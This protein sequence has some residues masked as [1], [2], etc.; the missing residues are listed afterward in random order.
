[1]FGLAADRHQHDVGLDRLGRAALGGLDGER[2]L[3]AVARHAG[4]LGASRNS[5][6]CFLKILLAS[7][8]TSSSKP[9]RIWSRNSTHGDLGAEPP[10]DRAELQPDHAAADHDHVPGHLRRAP[11][12]RSN[13]RSLFWSISTPGSGV[14]DEPVAMTMFFARTVRSPTLTVSGALE[15]RMALQPFDLVLLEQEFDAAG[16][17][18]DRLEARAVHRAEVELDA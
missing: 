14:T 12:R 15:A 11:A 6:P 18:L 17:A 9:G 16:Q 1:M 13:R 7:L 3:A 4:D 8:R 5:K 2:R 10:P